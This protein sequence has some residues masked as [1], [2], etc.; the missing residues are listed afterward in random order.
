MTEGTP[1]E[2]Q[3]C[4]SEVRKNFQDLDRLSHLWN[5]SRTKQLILW[6]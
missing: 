1:S 4:V 2:N 6:L 3:F 5:D